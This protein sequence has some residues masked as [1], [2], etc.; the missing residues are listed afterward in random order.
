MKYDIIG[1]KMRYTH[2]L[3]QFFNHFANI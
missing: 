2:F 1:A 3:V